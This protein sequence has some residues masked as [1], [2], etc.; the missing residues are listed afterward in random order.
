MV[1]HLN[2]YFGFSYEIYDIQVSTHTHIIPT[3]DVGSSVCYTIYSSIMI[4]IIFTYHILLCSMLV[5]SSM[6][7]CHAMQ[8]CHVFDMYAVT[9][10]MQL[11]EPKEIN[12]TQATY[13]CISF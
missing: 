11:S 12:C 10:Q 13:I 7:V 8:V 1:Y 2:R 3:Y 9:F 5:C 6:R 4:C